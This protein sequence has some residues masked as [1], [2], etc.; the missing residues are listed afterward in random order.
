MAACDRSNLRPRP[1]LPALLLA[2]ILGAGPAA[3]ATPAAAE[4][5]ID[6]SA[7]DVI[8]DFRSDTVELSGNVRVSQGPTSIEAQEAHGKDFHSD[9]SRWTFQDAVH[10]RT[11]E[12]EL[13]SATATADFVR[14]QLRGAR[15]EG[16]PAVFEQRGATTERQI[17]GRAG[18]IEYDFVHGIITMTNQVWFSNGKDEFRGD[19]V[20]YNVRD[21]RLQVNPGPASGRVRGTIRPRPSTSAPKSEPGTGAAA[22]IGSE[23]GA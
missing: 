21:E 5:P 6:W 10:I 13:Q 14:N 12:V 8:S 11:A 20:I 17:R 7:D 15:I 19:V 2:S 16:T 4:R 1:G 22:E 23:K 9:N 3:G 18:V